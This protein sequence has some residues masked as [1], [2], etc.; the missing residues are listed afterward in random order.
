MRPRVRD[1]CCQGGLYTM[2]GISL[3]E[4]PMEGMLATGK[5][6]REKGGREYI[7]YR[8]KDGEKQ[9]E[10]KREREKK[11]GDR[12]EIVCRFLVF[13]YIFMVMAHIFI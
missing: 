5:T 3:E 10:K 2:E 12:M 8:E 6:K 7:R 9:G 11:D 4:G 13:L 1:L